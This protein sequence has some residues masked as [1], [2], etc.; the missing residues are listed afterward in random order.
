MSYQMMRSLGALGQGPLP[1]AEQDC[2]DAGGTW[3]PD[4][5]VKCDLSAVLASE[6]CIASGGVWN[7]T[8][9]KCEPKVPPPDAA[10]P[11]KGSSAAVYTLLGLGLV[12]LAFYV[13]ARKG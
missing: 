4:A 9:Y 12:G 7:D 3:Y 13:S 6:K 2:L 11:K 5:A 1:E 10:A 8:T